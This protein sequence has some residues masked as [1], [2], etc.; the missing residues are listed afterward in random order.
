[1]LYSK[2][3][4]F[5]FYQDILEINKFRMLFKYVN[6]NIVLMYFKNIYYL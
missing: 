5:I 4:H 6:I 1:M 3:Y 2:L